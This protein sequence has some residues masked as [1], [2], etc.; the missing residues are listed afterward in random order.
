[1]R[2]KRTIQSY[3]DFTGTSSLKIVQEY[4]CKYLRI[5]NILKANPGLLDAVHKDL[6]RVL[7][8]SPKGRP[9]KYTSD[10]ILRALIVMFIEGDSFRDLVIRIENSEFLRTFVGFGVQST[11]NYTFLCKAFGCLSAETWEA[12]NRRLGDYALATGQLTGEKL[13]I[14]TTAVETNIHFPTDACLLWDSYRTIVRLLRHL[15]Q[16]YPCLS[17]RFRF[18]KRRVKTLY[19]FIARNGKSV[20]KSVQRKVK[21]AYRNLGQA[22]ERVLAIAA[23]VVRILPGRDPLVAELSH[24]LPLVERVIDQ[25]RRRVF[26]GEKVPADEKLY[27]LFEE[28]TELLMRGKARAPIEF[29]HMVLIGQTEEKFISQYKV[30]CPRVPDN[31]LVEEV[32][33]AHHDLFACI[34]KVLAADKGFYENMA[35]IE[36]L[37][38][39][40]ETVSIGKKGSRTP[41]EKAR[42]QDARFKAEQRFRAGVEGSISVLKR[43]FKQDRCLFK[44]FKNFAASVGCAVFCHNLVLLTRL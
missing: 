27:S 17:G 38:E 16:A 14:D 9:S 24:Y 33:M 29:G 12:L 21:S 13:R 5:D 31:T 26:K 10:Q 40:I 4:R 42:E 43:V 32:L 30:V 2:T 39:L 41:A 23:E 20:Q 15:K 28:H 44:G 11:M 1:M 34:P 19:L 35:R 37:G 18:R 22:V 36:A 25:M 7:S 8:T 3:F 6:E